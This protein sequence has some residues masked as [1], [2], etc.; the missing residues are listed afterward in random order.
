MIERE[1]DVF[2]LVAIVKQLAQAIGFSYH[3]SSALS[4]AV[5]EIATNVIRYANQGQVVISRTENQKGILVLI[6]DSGPGIE[7]LDHVMQDGVSSLKTSMGLGFGA[8]KRAVDSLLVNKSDH[9]GTSI[10]LIKYLSLNV[11]TIDVG[12]VSFPI[13]GSS[14]NK[15][16]LL[17]KAFEGEKILVAIFDYGRCCQ[18][19]E[20]LMGQLFSVVQAHYQLSFTDMKTLLYTAMAKKNCPN[21]LAC[22]MLKI[23]PETVDIMC[24]GKGSVY[25]DT[26]SESLYIG[27]N[28]SGNDNFTN[29]IVQTQFPTPNEYLYIL[30]SDGVKG[31]EFES[32]YQ[33]SFSAQSIA[34]ME[35]DAH[36][37]SEDDAS[38]I[39]IKGK[40]SNEAT[41]VDY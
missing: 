22:S 19:C 32:S 39:V 27:E 16:K 23:T 40:K 41:Y 30:Y 8:A 26:C 38:V 25:L 3:D 21:I 11:E 24:F 20:Q 35:F 7:D 2:E 1:F 17:I 14:F 5:S 10:T 34:M 29:G 31:G 18:E 28:L 36:A 12:R 13:V 15:D 4:L 9:T 33:C 37:L 6:E